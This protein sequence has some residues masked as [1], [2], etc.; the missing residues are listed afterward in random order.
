[1][2]RFRCE[3]IME[4]QCLHNDIY[5]TTCWHLHNARHLD[6]VT[7][8]E[9]SLFC[10][11]LLQKRP[12]IWRSLLISMLR[13]RALCRCRDVECL[14]IC[15]HLCVYVCV[16]VYVHC[17]DAIVCVCLFG[18]RVSSARTHLLLHGYVWL[19]MWVCALYTCTPA[20]VCTCVCVRAFVCVTV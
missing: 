12:I 14:H 6:I 10:R 18:C 5:T 1:M 19:C 13:S 15:V 4:T 11:A 20:C 3:D 8:A 2:S 16:Y 7:F 17:V 9:Y